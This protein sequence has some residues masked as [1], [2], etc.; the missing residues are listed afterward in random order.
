MANN[1][2]ATRGRRYKFV[3]ATVEVETPFGKVTTLSKTKTRKVVHNVQS[4]NY[5]K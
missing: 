4:Y 5:F 1:R 2:K 3:P